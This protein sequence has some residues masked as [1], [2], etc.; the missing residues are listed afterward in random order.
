MTIYL[1]KFG[2]ILTSRQSGNEAF[3][4]FEPSLNEI[5]T[6]E[7][8]IIDFEGVDVFAPSWA[9]EFLT[10]LINKYKNE[11]SFKNTDN[12]SVQETLKFLE[13]IHNYKFIIEK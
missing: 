13:K 6:N 1:K 12:I 3:A 2:A 11:L 5:N 9:D 7:K 8:I 10:L 4:A